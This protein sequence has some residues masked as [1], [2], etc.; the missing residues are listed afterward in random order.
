MLVTTY[1]GYWA[2]VAEGQAHPRP[3][4]PPVKRESPIRLSSPSP[5]DHDTEYSDELRAAITYKKKAEKQIV[6]AKRLSKPCTLVQEAKAA[7]E[8]AESDYHGLLERPSS[9]L[10]LRVSPTQLARALRIADALVKHVEARGWAVEVGRRGTFVH[11]NEVPIGI[12][13]EEST[14]AHEVPV[15][16]DSEWQ[17]RLSLQSSPVRE[18][19]VGPF[20]DWH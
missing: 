5:E 9:C 3:A 2:K 6:V 1:P 17:L 13:I 7:L 14:V 20:V 16:G 11:I 15:K 8:I 19:T 18:K 12:A 10:D 4:L